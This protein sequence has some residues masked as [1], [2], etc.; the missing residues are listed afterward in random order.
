M[1]PRPV[2]NPRRHW[3]GAKEHDAKKALE[4]ARSAV[5]VVAPVDFVLP[6]IE[7]PAGRR[8]LR[9]DGVMVAAGGHDVGPVDIDIVGPRRIAFTGPNGVGKSTLLRIITGECRLKR[10]QVERPVRLACLDQDVSMFDA[11]LSLIEA[12]ERARPDLTRAVLHTAL[13]Q[14]GFRGANAEKPVAALSG[15]EKLRA[16]LAA[17]MSGEES[18]QLLLLDEPTNH[19]D[20]DALTALEA[21]L[22]A[23]NGGLIVV[24]HDSRFRA[25]V[26]VEREVAL[27]F[28]GV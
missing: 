8:L 22:A 24:S 3:L 11:D 9:L 10:G 23:W 15:G 5:E 6:Q 2:A 4:A 27:Q 1:P 19:L 12:A 26:G 21:A 18:C 25:A 14:A 17:V 13:A 16:G 7:V 20:L 28:D